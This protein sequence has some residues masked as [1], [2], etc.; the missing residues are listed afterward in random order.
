MLLWTEP[1]PFYP[2]LCLHLHLILCPFLTLF[3]DPYL[4]MLLQG[5]LT[6]QWSPF[7]VCIPQFF[8]PTPSPCPIM[9]V[10]LPWFLLFLLDLSLVVPGERLSGADP[11]IG[12]EAGPETTLSILLGD[13]VLDLL[14]TVVPCPAILSFFP[15]FPLGPTPLA[16]ITQMIP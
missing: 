13:N 15:Y 6:L 1:L 14:F 3:I 5:P 8:L 4:Y 9:V 16:I 12:L 2:T 7:P 10:F 11:E